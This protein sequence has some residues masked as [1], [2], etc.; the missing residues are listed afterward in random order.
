M[1]EVRVGDRVVDKESMRMGVVLELNEDTGQLRVDFSGDIDWIE[2]G[3]ATKMLL[4]TE[5]H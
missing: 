1:K 3:S 2:E 5:G 4:E